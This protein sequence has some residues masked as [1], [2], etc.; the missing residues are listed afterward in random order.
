MAPSVLTVLVGGTIVAIV[1]LGWL[2]PLIIGIVRSIKEAV[3]EVEEVVDAT[4]H[5]SGENPY[6]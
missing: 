1:A 4:D 5:N 2:V 6:Y 3:P